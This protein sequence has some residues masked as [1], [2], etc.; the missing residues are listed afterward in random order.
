MLEH[1]RNLFWPRDN[2]AH[3]MDR[4]A[5]QPAKI[6]EIDEPSAGAGALLAGTHQKSETEREL[7]KAVG[8]RR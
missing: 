7:G 6:L 5:E 4:S 1:L 3:L 2:E 8:D